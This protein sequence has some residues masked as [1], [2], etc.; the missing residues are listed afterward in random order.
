MLFALY[1]SLHMIG[2]LVA[3]HSLH[4][5]CLSCCF[6]EPQEDVDQ[7]IPKSMLASLILPRQL[8]PNTRT[9]RLLCAGTQLFCAGTL[10]SGLLRPQLTVIHKGEGRSLPQPSAAAEV[11]PF[12]CVLPDN[13]LV[14]TA[15]A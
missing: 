5:Q 11:D 9:T 2:C 8:C 14:T 13:V 4:C 1:R 7:A 10:R 3:L 12:G 6:V 15:Q